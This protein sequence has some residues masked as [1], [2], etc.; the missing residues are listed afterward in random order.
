MPPKPKTQATAPADRRGQILQLAAEMFFERGYEATTMREL[1]GAIQ[2]ESASLY[3][4]FP[5][6]EQILFELIESVMRQLIGGARHLIAHERT[7]EHRLA[8]LV[9]NHVVLHATRPKESTLGDSELRSLTKRHFRTNIRRRDE[10]ERLVMSIL[11]EGVDAGRFSLIEPKLTTYAI[12]AQSS[13]VGTWYRASGRL[14]LQDVAS[15]YMALALRSV[16]AEPLSEDDV[17]RL[18]ADARLFHE[19][20]SD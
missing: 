11:N 2:I 8:A 3:Y 5:N 10:Y 19:S 16:A 9:V 18:L 6:K 14:S 20:F 13:H 7:P 12:I 4:F 17:Q 15:A 1:A